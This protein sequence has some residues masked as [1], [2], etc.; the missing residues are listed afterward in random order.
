MPKLTVAFVE[1]LGTL[2]TLGTRDQLVMDDLVSGFGLRL[3]PGGK[4]LFLVKKRHDGKIVKRTFGQMV[5]GAEKPAPGIPAM[6]IKEARGEA[7]RL[8]GLVA[9]GEAIDDDRLTPP[10]ADKPKTFQDVADQWLVEHVRPKLKPY[11][12]RDYE[13]IVAA[14]A[15]RFGDKLFFGITKADVRKLHAEM[16]DRP[17]RANYYLQVISAIYNFAEAPTNPAAKIVKYREGRRERIMSADELIAALDAIVTLERNGRLSAWACGAMRFAIAT[18]ARP[19]EIKA[20]EWKFVDFERKRVVLPDSKANRPRI[21]YTNSAAWAVIT[22]LKRYGRFVFAGDRPDTAYQN[23]TR[24]WEKVRKIAKLD[25]VRLYDCRHTFASEAAKAGHNLPMI[26][27][28]L[29]HTVPATTQRY[30]HLVDDPVARASQ[31]VGDAMEAARGRRDEGAAVVP[32]KTRGR[33]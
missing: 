23:L 10:V 5:I 2:G 21:I 19:S 3:T 7:A 14:L 15:P 25:E 17:R 26:G 32:L 9:S 16:A 31:D 27:A 8:L 18:G 29:G 12:V 22:T 1:S 28:L 33:R 24:A 20:I 4:R 13:R 6:T 11:T 30:V